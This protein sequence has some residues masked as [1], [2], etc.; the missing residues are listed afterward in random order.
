MPVVGVAL[1]TPESSMRSPMRAAESLCW[2]VRP[3]AKKDGSWRVSQRMKRASLGSTRLVI[4]CF[5]NCSASLTSSE[6]GPRRPSRSRTACARSSTVALPWSLAAAPSITS[7]LRPLRL[8]KA[9]FT[10]SDLPLSISVDR[11]VTLSSRMSRYS[12]LL[13][14]LRRADSLFLSSLRCFFWDIP[15]FSPVLA[16][17]FAPTVNCGM[18]T[19][20]FSGVEG[21]AM[22]SSMAVESGEAS[23]E[24]EADDESMLGAAD[25]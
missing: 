20:C 8:S 22:A 5:W 23:G 3:A 12:F 16:S 21:G 14:L 17:S 1:L 2:S 4:C 9:L 24:G 15:V 19:L 13:F 10:C 7:F 18:L 6:L 25:P 11:L